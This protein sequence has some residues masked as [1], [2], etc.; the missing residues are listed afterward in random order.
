MM[1]AMAAAAALSL[2]P[3]DAG[4][5]TVSNVRVTHGLIG[6]TRADDKVLPGDAV[7]LCFDV[8]G[9]TCDNEGK[10]HYSTSLEFQDGKGKTLVKKDPAKHDVVVSLGGDRVPAFA[11]IDVGTETPEG[12]YVVKVV[13]ADQA[14]GKSQ[15]ISRT[16][17][18][19]PKDFGLVRLTTTSDSEGLLPV[20]VPGSGEGLWVNFGVVGFGRGAGKQPDVSFGMRVLDADG[21]PVHAKPLAAQV[22]KDV[23]A[24]AAL[25]PMQ[26]MLSLN[27]PGKFTLELTATDAVSKKTAKLSVPLTIQEAAK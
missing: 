20:S 19:L 8:A 7:F 17:T 15:T 9:V 24:D 5:L 12:E 10:V 3:A 23:P 26:F 16:F 21:K 27:R 2:A 6:P 13:V 11:R 14:S 4:E 1:W 25:I 22:N 18:V